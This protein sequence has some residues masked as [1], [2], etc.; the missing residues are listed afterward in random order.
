MKNGNISLKSLPEQ[1]SGVFAGFVRHAIIF[2]IIFIAAAYGFVLYRISTLSSVEPSDQAVAT[3]AKTPHLNKDVIEQLK[4]LNDNSVS[5]HTLFN[6][7]RNN[8]FN[9]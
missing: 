1:L 3:Q 6:D 4:Q 7:S 5:V 9:E 8:P 2:F